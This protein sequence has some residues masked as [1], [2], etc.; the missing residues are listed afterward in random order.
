MVNKTGG[1]KHKKKKK[2]GFNDDFKRQLLFKENLQ[3]Y[4]VILEN[5]GSAMNIKL[6]GT[7]SYGTEIRGIIRG[8]MKRTKMKKGDHILISLREYEHN[9]GDIIHKYTPD[10]VKSLIHYNEITNLNQDNQE[11]IIDF[12]HDESEFIDNI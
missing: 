7:N 1:K 4:G 11:N 12:E 5:V 2:G 9:V 8:K 10:E 3:E 6:I